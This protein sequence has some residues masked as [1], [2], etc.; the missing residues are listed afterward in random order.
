MRSR[1]II[2]PDSVEIGHIR[3][4]P[5]S[6]RWI[7]LN[8]NGVSERESPGMKTMWLGSSTIR[9]Q[10][11]LVGLRALGCEHVQR[12]EEPKVDDA[13]KE[14]AALLAVGRITSGCLPLRG[15]LMLAPLRV[16]SNVRARFTAYHLSFLFD[17]GDT[18]MPSTRATAVQPGQTKLHIFQLA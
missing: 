8:G 12:G 9:A 15:F 1:R 2:L 10:I 11:T 6:L 18:G 7:R 14:I 5:V 4:H 17:I 16:G 13:S 3:L